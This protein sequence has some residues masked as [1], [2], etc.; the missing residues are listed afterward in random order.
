MR[1]YLHIT[2]RSRLGTQAGQDSG[3][4]HRHSLGVSLH[5]I[6]AS[7]AIWSD[8]S[9]RVASIQSVPFLP[10]V[11]HSAAML[12]M[13]RPRALFVA[14]GFVFVTL[15]TF[16]SFSSGSSV[17]N[18]E[19]TFNV[20]LEVASDNPHKDTSTR[21]FHLLTTATGNDLN[22]CRLVLSAAVLSYPP[23]VLLAWHGEGDFDA[24]ETHLAKVRAPLRYFD[25]LPPSSEDDLVLLIDGYDVIFQLGPDVLLQ[26]YHEVVKASNARLEEQFGADHIKKHNM[27]TTIL[28]GPDV[29]CYPIDFRRPACWIVPEST[30]PRD[31]FGSETD[32]NDEHTR[33]R[34]L[35]S[36]TILG[37]V[38]DLRRLF[39]A[40]MDKV[41]KTWDPEFY[42][43]NSDQ[44]YLADVWADQEFVRMTS[45]G[46]NA[47]FPLPDAVPD[48]VKPNIFTP[49]PEDRKKAEQH[50]GI[51]YE[52]RLFQ[53]VALFYD[54]LQWATFDKPQTFVT[55]DEIHQFSLKLPKDVEQSKAPYRAL[56]SWGWGNAWLK[57]KSW[58]DVPLGINTVTR[59]MFPI[60]HFTGFKNYRDEW[61]DRMWFFP[62]AEKLLK[63]KPDRSVITT[64]EGVEWVPYLPY[65]KQSARE[66]V[67]A[68]QGE[69]L[70]WD[71]LCGEHESALY[72]GWREPPP[73]P[74][75]EKQEEHE[76]EKK[77]GKEKRP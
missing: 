67:W 41:D 61:W 9:S 32:K 46:K 69:L 47:T 70:K 29:L 17:V 75:P 59:N 43:R 45:T 3:I 68:D 39:E 49:A 72:N 1:P 60:I 16:Y 50:M 8:L 15:V 28:F 66:D 37:P 12:S 6:L 24:A 2:Q 44:M 33:P 77:E 48:D 22:V 25:T 20:D 5:T 38:K 4:R 10:P 35:N 63:A 26:R 53:T 27:H 76:E 65:G 7:N 30:L 18:S 21:G 56:S 52:S 51:D 42:G 73:E 57:R 34:W 40:T 55:K 36:G 64:I 62:L 58:K 14:V 19:K 11:T 71:G 13:P 23:T 54:V 31:A 74:E